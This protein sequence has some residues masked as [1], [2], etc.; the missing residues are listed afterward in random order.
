M[1]NKSPN[2]VWKEVT[3]D[4]KRAIN[5]LNL[6]KYL[7][8]IAVISIG[9]LSILF[10]SNYPPNDIEIITLYPCIEQAGSWEPV[11]VLKR[12][13][14]LLFCGEVK[15]NYLPREVTVRI[16]LEG[17][18]KLVYSD[19]VILDSKE[20]SIKIDEKIQPGS[21]RLETSRGRNKLSQTIFTIR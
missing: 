8:V 3:M 10:G 5:Y 17:T 9:I 2:L 21:Y 18:D 6:L 16:F 4:S 19:A 15:T 13:A 1:A 20:F 12:E 11:Q 7:I 14:P